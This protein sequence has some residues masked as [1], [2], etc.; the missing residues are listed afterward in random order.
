MFGN[1][2]AGRP[3]QA[4]FLITDSTFMGISGGWD[5]SAG[6]GAGAVKSGARPQTAEII[7]TFGERCPEIVVNN[8]EMADYVVIL[9]HQGGKGVARKTEQDRCFRP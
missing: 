4:S 2:T 1:S 3:S 6:T 9:D 8:K 5:E 7:K